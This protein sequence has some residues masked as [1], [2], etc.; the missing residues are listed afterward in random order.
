MKNEK[1]VVEKVNRMSARLII[2][3]NELIPRSSQQNGE[4][5]VCT[6]QERGRE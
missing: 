4:G 1:M 6:R 3:S 2:E 5:D